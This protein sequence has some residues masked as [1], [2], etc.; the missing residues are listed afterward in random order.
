MPIDKTA[1]PVGIIGL[2]SMG[3]GSALALGEAGFD[4]IGFDISE[5]TCRKLVAR[6]GRT[7]GSSVKVVREA[8][9][10]LAGGVNSRQVEQGLFG[11]RWG[12][13]TPSSPAVW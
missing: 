9:I 5:E 2:G 11:S 1:G 3:L 7:V 12:G 10:V 4:V 13:W 6:G 8:Q